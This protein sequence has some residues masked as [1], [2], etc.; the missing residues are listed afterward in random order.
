MIRR[1]ILPKGTFYIPW[2]IGH[3]PLAYLPQVKLAGIRIW[4]AGI[5][6]LHRQ[7]RVGWHQ[8]NRAWEIIAFRQ[9]LNPEDTV[10]DAG[11]IF[12]SLQYRMIFAGG[13]IGA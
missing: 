10:D 11:S 5:Y 1:H 7:V 12:K 2:D 13:R 4:F 3:A 8:G 9:H 6:I